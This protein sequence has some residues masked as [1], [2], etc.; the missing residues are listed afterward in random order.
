[1]L[2]NGHQSYHLFA[3]NLEKNLSR[4]ETFLFYSFSFSFIKVYD[5]ET[6]EYQN[7]QTI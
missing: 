4:L 3:L 2:Q 5:S 7:F 6:V 1:M